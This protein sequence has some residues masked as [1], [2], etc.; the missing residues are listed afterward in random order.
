MSLK[1]KTKTLSIPSLQRLTEALFP[2]LFMEKSIHSHL[3]A[4]ALSTRERRLVFMAGEAFANEAEFQAEAQKL[5]ESIQN[6]EMETAAAQAEIRVLQLRAAL[7]KNPGRNVKINELV[8]SLRAREDADSALT[9]IKSRTAKGNVE[10]DA[11]VKAV[12]KK[13]GDPAEQAA[14]LTKAKE[15][16]AKSFA[17]ING[18]LKADKPYNYLAQIEAHAA[19]VAKTKELDPTNDELA[20]SAGEDPI[21]LDAA[22]SDLAALTTEHGTYMLSLE[23]LLKTAEGIKAADNPAARE[24]AED[25]VDASVKAQ[26][27]VLEGKLKTILALAPQYNAEKQ[28]AKIFENMK[29]IDDVVNA[30][31]GRKVAPS[32]TPAATPAN[33]PAATPANAPANAAPAAPTTLLGRGAE[34]LKNAVTGISN[35]AK[36]VI[37]KGAE[38]IDSLQDGL[39]DKQ[40]A[41]L[42][43]NLNR[44]LKKQGANKHIV[45]NP[46]TGKLEIKDGAPPEETKAAEA[47]QEVKNKLQELLDFFKQLI[48]FLRGERKAGGDLGVLKSELESIDEQIA[49]L[50]K[51]NPD[52][53]KKPDVLKK[54]ED[55]DRQ[56]EELKLKI[57]QGKKLG[58]EVVADAK[59]FVKNSAS[60]GTPLYLTVQKDKDGN[61]YLVSTPNAPGATPEKCKSHMQYMA[62]RLQQVHPELRL[63]Q[64]ASVDQRV[65][66]NVYGDVN[67]NSKNNNS[68]NITNTN[69]INGDNN[70]ASN[71]ADRSQNGNNDSLGGFGTANEGTA[72]NRANRSP[73]VTAEQVVTPAPTVEPLRPQLVDTPPPTGNLPGLS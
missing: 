23:P 27:L 29:N 35:L 71:T 24:T 68:R 16:V 15:L 47:P 20:G 43:T 26:E 13:E 49:K 66:F 32:V 64:R 14:Q 40:K 10:W 48:E 2:S 21:L 57:E 25:Q 46:D 37:A 42:M 7:D 67:I 9:E 73:N 19:N 39:S 69:T 54:I 28:I 17:D 56:R 36:D 63:N 12:K 53:S 59:T 55:L 3:F 34:L 58:S 70:T 33:A 51:D 50:K 30:R 8:A 52:F 11:I 31:L 61:V 22:D 44:E 38:A 62:G 6:P 5:S 1:S 65:Y 72:R 41:E 60:A 45:Q 18:L 4:S